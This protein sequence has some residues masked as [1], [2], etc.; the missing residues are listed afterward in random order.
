M[1][2]CLTTCKRTDLDFDDTF[3]YAWGDL[4]TTPKGYMTTFSMIFWISNILKLYVEFYRKAT[5]ENLVWVPIID[6]CTNHFTDEVIDAFDEIGNIKLILLP[7]HSSHLL[8]MLEA[9]LFS[10]VKQWF[11]SIPEN[12]DFM[13][14]LTCKSMRIKRAYES[15]VCSELIC[16]AW[17]TTGFHLNL[18]QGEVT[19]LV[20]WFNKFSKF[21]IS[22]I[23]LT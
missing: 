15:S 11:S 1:P 18:T 14:R 21:S 5:D 10:S 23:W 12:K 3:Y 19:F 2:L 22:N 17:E 13:S 6:G 9:T 8:Q 7:P 4:C 16:S 20:N